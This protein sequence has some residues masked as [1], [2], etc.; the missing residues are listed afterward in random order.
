M[1]SVLMIHMRWQRVSVNT[2]CADVE[3]LLLGKHRVGSPE[4]QY[5]HYQTIYITLLYVCFRLKTPCSV[6]SNYG[7][8]HCN[9]RLNEAYRTH[10]WS[11]RKA[12]HN[13]LALRNTRKYFSTPIGSHFKN[14]KLTKKKKRSESVALNGQQKGPVYSTQAGLGGGLPLVRP[15]LGPCASGD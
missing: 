13:L 12:H 2:E 6:T 5:F 7:R 4:S 14:R 11:L 9:S 15:Q 1:Q 8:Q 10:T 3:P